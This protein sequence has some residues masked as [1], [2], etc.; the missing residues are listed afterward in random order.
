VRGNGK[1]IQELEAV[2]RGAGWN[3]I[4]VIWG[5][6]WDELFAN[7]GEGVLLRRC[8]DVVD[9][10]LQR[11]VTADGAYTRQHFF[12]TDPRLLKLVE[13]LSDEDIRHLRRGG[14]SFRKLYAAYKAAVE[15]E[16]KPTAILAHTVK[17]WT[18]GE[19]FEGSNVTHQKKKL[20]LEELKRFRDVIE[21]PVPDSQIADAP[22]YHPGPNSEE[23]QYLIERRR[24]LGGSIPKRRT[25]H[26]VAIDLP[27]DDLYAEFHS[28][29]KTGEAST[30]MVFTRLLS[31]L[32]RDKSI[33]RRIV[34]IVPDEAR[35]F[36]MDA[37]FS[38][39]GIYSSHGQLYE[40]VDKG[41][42]IYYRETKDGQVLE[43]G[44]TEAG[45][46]ASFVA[47][48]TAHAVHGQPTIPF[49]IFYSM[50]GFQRTGDQIWAAG[51]AMVRG[52]LLGATA[53]RTTL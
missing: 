47:A 11:Y 2:F 36:G 24:A 45:S 41:R 8:N 29:M 10:E 7:D 25:T 38:Q 16:G 34:P 28:G 53:G 9:G 6:E 18:L 15:Y 37:L 27:K 46:M 12:G 4:K 33:G 43:E 20:E 50:F 14:H 35:T 48:G 39:V 23:V 40:P 17:G 42:L 22:F 19:G 51:D 32:L 44:I 1:I 13:H 30:T 3:V 52:F 49:Y 31:K 26:Q 21:L 5:P